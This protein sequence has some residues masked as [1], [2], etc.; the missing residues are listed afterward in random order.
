MPDL[1][2]TKAMVSEAGASV[3]SASELAAKEFPDLDV[4]LRGA[5]SIARR[6]QDPLA[7]LVKIDP[8]SI[9]VGQYQH[10]VDQTRPRALA[11]RG[12]GGLRERRGRRR[13]HRLR[14][15]ADARLGP[16]TRRS[17]PT[18]SPTATRTAPSQS[19][20]G[21]QEGAAPRPQGLRA[22]GRL[23]AHPGRREPA[24]RQR[25]APRALS[26]WWRR[27]PRRPARP[28]EVHDRRRAFLKALKP[29]TLR[30]RHVRHADR[31][32]TSSPSWRSPAATRA[33]SSRPP[34]SP[35]AWTKIERPEARHG[36]SKAW[37]PTSPPSAPSSTSAC[38][39]TAWCTSPSWPTASS[40]TRA[41]S[42]RRATW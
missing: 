4:T 13:E 32:A 40:R 22:G 27:S 15:A 41:R 37:S 11:R 38:T 6:L 19:R 34:P 31:D 20:S 23:P 21:S 5:V 30:R 12:G 33:P 9:G 18:S 7:E 42:S 10:D 28:L 24:R 17:P 2:L 26:A 14:A 36:C 1:K 29:A 35:R 25:R 3:Y 8:K 39:R 16:R